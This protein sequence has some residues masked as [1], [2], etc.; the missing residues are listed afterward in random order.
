M[1][2]LS[3]SLIGL[4]CLLM[5]I[6]G[7]RNKPEKHF[8]KIKSLLGEYTGEIY[9]NLNKENSEMIEI[10]YDEQTQKTSGGFS[11]SKKSVSVNAALIR[12]MEIDSV[13]YQIKDIE[14]KQDKRYRN[15]CV[16]LSYGS[17]E[18]GLYR[19]GTKTD[20]ES[21][22]VCS[23]SPQRF[24]MASHPTFENNKIY[25]LFLFSECT[26][27]NASLNELPNGFITGQMTTAEKLDK[28]KELIDQSKDC[29][30]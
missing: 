11:S 30:K 20:P 9:I 15:C 13:V 21:A 6:T 26:D 25:W 24:T 5:I 4:S 12:S 2:S 14:Y 16:R 1:R 18:F 8:G 22:I 19:W 10:V 23:Q 28:F 29:V 3:Y 7:S 27:L 17:A